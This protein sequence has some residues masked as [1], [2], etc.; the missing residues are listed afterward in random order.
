[1]H[2]TGRRSSTQRSARRSLGLTALAA[3]ASLLVACS[4]TEPMPA[5]LTGVWGG[6]M[7]YITPSDS[8]AFYL[9]QSGAQVQGWGIFFSGGGPGSNT[10]FAGN[11]TVAGDQ[12][13]M[14]LTDV[15]ANSGILAG[16]YTLS[17]PVGRSPMNAVFA[18]GGQSYPIALRVSRPPADLAGTWALQST[19]GA[20]APAGLLDTIVVN[21]DGR[22]YRHREGDYAFGTQGMWSRRGNFM[23]LDQAGGGLLK[24]SLLIGSTELQRTTVVSGGATRAEHYTRVSTSAELP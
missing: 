13:T 3:V 20:A 22:A 21:A 9:K 15:T 19:T 12:L 6:R 18:G 4:S 23:V 8:F 24:D 10:H 11:G 17:G 7:A 14:T 5:P 2:D 16:T 1:M